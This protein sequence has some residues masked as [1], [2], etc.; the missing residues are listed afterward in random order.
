MKTP[1]PATWARTAFGMDD[2]GAE[3]IL[4]KATHRRGRLAVERAE[5][6]DLATPPPG[7][8]LAACLLQRESF[9]RW[10]TAPIASARKARAVLPSLLDIELPFPVEECEIALLELHPTPDRGGT[11]GLV[12]GARA[13]DIGRRLEALAAA[14]LDV[15]MLDQEGIALWSRGLEELPPVPGGPAG[16][17]VVYLGTDRVTLAAGQDGEF[18]VAQAMR[19]FD[20]AAVQRLLK[21]AFASPPEKTHWIWAGPGA[22]DT[23]AVT[24][25][26]PS[27]A[28]RWP[29]PMTILPDPGPFLARALATRALSRG[30]DRCNLRSGRFLHPSFARRQQRQPFQ[31][32]LATL[33]AGLLLCAVNLAWILAVQH[34]ARTTEQALHALAGG[35]TGNRGVIPRGQECRT[36]RLALEARTRQMEPFLAATEATAADMLTDILTQARENGASVETLTLGTKN[37]VIHGFAPGLAQGEQM[38][39]GLNARGWTT[40]IERKES[41]PGSEQTAFVIAMGRSRE[42]R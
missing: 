35:I 9:T 19:Q 42:K 30:S 8:V 31:W 17:V 34:R 28:E 39:R 33:A 20:P 41:A 21:S 12:A 3:P 11:R 25:L 40:T 2:S 29:G 32:A 38:A 1:A 15:H 37:G 14:G 24:T 36:A 6:R 10:V 4:V 27:V 26:H 22:T 18:A 13:T 7:S 5:R 16:R 23:A